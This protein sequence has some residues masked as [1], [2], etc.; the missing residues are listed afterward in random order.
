MLIYCD[1]G[2]VCI[3]FFPF[4]FVCAVDIDICFDKESM[5]VSAPFFF[6]F[7]ELIF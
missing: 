5:C 1:C 2:F 6:S 3:F 7:L 4:I